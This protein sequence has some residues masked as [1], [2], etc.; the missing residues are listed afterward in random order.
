MV[1]RSTFRSL[2]SERRRVANSSVCSAMALAARGSAFSCSRPSGKTICGRPVRSATSRASAAA[3]ENHWPR[4]T[5]YCER[6]WVPSKR[7]STW[8]ALTV[9][10]SRTASSTILLPTSGCTDLRLSATTTVPGDGTPAS[11][12]AVAAQAMKPPKPAITRIQPQRRGRASFRS[13]LPLAPPRGLATGLGG[14]GV[15]DM[16]RCPKA[17]SR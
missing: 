15:A 14:A 6:A 1:A 12:G 5:S 2:S 4:A 7:T 9:S 10:P 17:W 8:P 11:S 3:V 13:M 16:S